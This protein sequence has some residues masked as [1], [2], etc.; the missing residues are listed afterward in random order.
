MPFD[1]TVELDE[2]RSG[3]KRIRDKHGR[4][5]N[6]KTTVSGI[7]KQGGG[8]YAGVSPNTSKSILKNAIGGHIP[9]GSTIRAGGRRSCRGLANMGYR[10]FRGE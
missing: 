8:V 1:G 6:V 10:A 9:V 5:A 4:G 7:L 3:T 2:S